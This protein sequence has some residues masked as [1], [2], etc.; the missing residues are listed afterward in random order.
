MP[1]EKAYGLYDGH[2][3]KH[4]THRRRALGVYLTHK[5]RVSHVVERSHQHTDNGRHSQP[6]NQ[7]RNGSRS[8][9]LV[10]LLGGMMRKM[11]GDN[12]KIRAKLIETAEYPNKKAGQIAE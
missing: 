3:R 8:Q 1:E 12:I 5:V 11:H 2:Q 7:S 9:L 10:V 6:G 4:D